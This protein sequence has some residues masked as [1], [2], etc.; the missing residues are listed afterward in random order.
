MK[1]TQ[2]INR[3][4]K[5]LLINHHTT[6]VDLHTYL[7]IS[8]AAVSNIVKQLID[9]NI[10]IET[11]SAI[12]K[13]EGA[14]RNK[15]IISLNKKIGYYIGVS[16]TLEGLA[17]CIC[18]ALGE[19]IDQQFLDYSSFLNK[20]INL[21][22]INL[23]QKLLSKHSD[24]KVLG[25][26]IAI[27]GHYNSKDHKLISN[28]KMWDMFNLPMIKSYLNLPIIAENNVESMALARHLFN[29]D[30]NIEKFIFF[31]IGYGIFASFIDP[32]NIHP[33]TNYSVG[34]IGHSIVKLNGFQCECG[35]KGCLQTYISETWLLK[36]ARLLYNLADNTVIRELVKNINDV[37][38]DTIFKAYK[39][40]DEYIV[41]MLNEGMQYLSISI[42][43][44]LMTYDADTIYL[45]SPLLQEE[46]FYSKLLPLINEQ[47]RFV[48]TQKKT[49]INILKYDKYSG[50]IGG[51]A[52]VAMSELIKDEKYYGIALH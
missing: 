33:K 17:V 35:K 50:A 19:K 15:Q 20:D 21:L 43:N 38:L 25:I 44:L 28:N 23:V 52:L 7:G 5:Y 39:L 16:F 29:G 9:N 36:K 31:N 12:S 40:N 18:N 13:Q 51:C 49:K 47:L 27:P 14:G 48:N 41:N 3:T 4:I 26:G 10:I 30:N 34:E 37:T 24:L 42:S 32:N 46:P 6:R 22:I 8:S 11:G 2:T 45:N 1:R